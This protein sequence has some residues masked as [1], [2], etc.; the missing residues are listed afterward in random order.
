MSLNPLPRYRHYFTC[1]RLLTF[2]QHIKIKPAVNVDS[3][4]KHVADIRFGSVGNSSLTTS[5]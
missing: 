1:Y 4:I 5:W 2:T 3:R